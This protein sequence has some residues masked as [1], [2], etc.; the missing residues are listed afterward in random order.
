MLSTAATSK[1]STTTATV[2][3]IVTTYPDYLKYQSIS[4][5]ETYINPRLMDD[6]VF[7]EYTKGRRPKN[8][9]ECSRLQKLRGEEYNEA[10]LES[11]SES[12]TN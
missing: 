9:Y 5:G 3:A 4:K 10:N 6:N 11:D 7:L 8:P 1:P 12:D 2:P